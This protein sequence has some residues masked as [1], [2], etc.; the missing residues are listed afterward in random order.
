ML[1]DNKCRVFVVSCGVSGCGE[2]VLGGAG[3]G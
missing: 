2:G 3:G 1:S